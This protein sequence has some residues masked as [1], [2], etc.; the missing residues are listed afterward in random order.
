[1][2]PVTQTLAQQ[3]SGSAGGQGFADFFLKGAQMA[4]NRRQLDLSERRLG[5]EETQARQSNLLFPLIKKAKEQELENLGLE[6]A[7][8]LQKKEM[9][10]EQNKALPE[11]L[12][13]QMEAMQSPKGF[14]SPEI[15]SKVRELS[16]RFPAAFS[17]GDGLDLMTSLKG[18]QMREMQLLQFEEIARDLEQRKTRLRSFQTS[19]NGAVSIQTEPIEPD[20]TLS[21]KGKEVSDYNSLIARGDVEGAAMIRAQ[22]ESDGFSMQFG[23][24]G[25]L[26][27]ISKGKPGQ[28]GLTTSVASSVQRN[29]LEA[30][31]NIV[32]ISSIQN[33]LRPQ[34]VGAF[35]VGKSIFLDKA[36][37]QFG[38]KTADI[39]RM[40]NRT[41]LAALSEGLLRDVSDDSRFS[42]ADRIALRKIV[43]KTGV[44]DS[45]DEAS[46]SMATLKNVFAKR[47]LIEHQTINPSAPPPNWALEAL[48]ITALAE[49]KKAGLIT[50]EQAVAEFKRREQK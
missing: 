6:V 32:E 11:I 41:K 42:N 33:T 43:D 12:A 8:N 13:I 49:S 1:M 35:A 27:S 21:T 44:M 38:F 48:S 22:M 24:D 47:A 30:R 40:D 18:A 19:P 37:P 26:L 25:K 7:I 2:D 46:S 4:Q 28:G 34:D 10:T 45:F 16:T 14:A 39:E 50:Q 20:G 31:K 9:I 15:I 3:Q 5:I 17:G 23:E 29:M 36:L